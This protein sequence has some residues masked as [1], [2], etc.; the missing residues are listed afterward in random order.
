LLPSTG[1]AQDES[2]KKELDSLQGAWQC[3]SFEEKGKA[4][5]EEQIK[6]LK[7]TFKGYKASHAGKDGKTEQA[8]IKIDPF[9]KPKMIDLMVLTGPDKGKTV[10]GIYMIEGDTLTICGGQVGRE[11]PTEFK[12][13]A[14]VNLMVFKRDKR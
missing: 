10:Q 7:L 2:V 9:K 13:G 3:V 6:D 12:G 1:A 8:T 5:P 4:L 11:R 14:E